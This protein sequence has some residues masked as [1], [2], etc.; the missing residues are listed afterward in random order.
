MKTVIVEYAY[1]TTQGLTEWKHKQTAKV[2]LP[3]V[4]RSHAVYAEPCECW[5]PGESFT[6]PLPGHQSCKDGICF[7]TRYHGGQ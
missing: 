5:A 1:K 2:M 7:R 6:Y 4:G 3:Q